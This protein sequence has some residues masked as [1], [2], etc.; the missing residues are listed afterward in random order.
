MTLCLQPSSSYYDGMG[1]YQDLYDK[2]LAKFPPNPCKFNTNPAQNFLGIVAYTYVSF[3]ESNQCPTRCMKQHAVRY[4][5]TWLFESKDVRASL[6]RYIDSEDITELSARLD[7]VMDLAIF[8]CFF[9]KP[10]SYILQR[11]QILCVCGL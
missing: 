8:C 5:L 10:V 6:F 2:T 4:N 7:K 1:L 9:E 11:L 3:H